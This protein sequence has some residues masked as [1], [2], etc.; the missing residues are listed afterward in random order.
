MEA[1]YTREKKA[2]LTRANLGIEKLRFLFRLAVELRYL[3]T[4]RY[5]HAARTIDDVG[6][7]VGG[8]LKF[9]RQTRGGEAAR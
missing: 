3:D 2:H 7:Q 4:K 5:E 6:R 1:T 8:W 9:E